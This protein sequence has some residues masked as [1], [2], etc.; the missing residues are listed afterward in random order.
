MLIVLT[1]ERILSFTCVCMYVD[2]RRSSRLTVDIVYNWFL[3]I[4]KNGLWMN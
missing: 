2:G 4:H 3:D 1:D